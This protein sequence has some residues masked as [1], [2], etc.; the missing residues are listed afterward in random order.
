[1]KIHTCKMS[2]GAYIFNNKQN[3]KN[4]KERMVEKNRGVFVIFVKVNVKQTMKTEG[5]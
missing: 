3:T 1:M 4:Q 5:I 2:R